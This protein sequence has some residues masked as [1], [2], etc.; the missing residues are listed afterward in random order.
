MVADQCPAE[1]KRTLGL[2]TL[3]L[4]GTEGV[5]PEEVMNNSARH[6]VKIVE[7]GCADLMK[8]V[9]QDPKT[10]THEK[11]TAIKTIHAKACDDLDHLRQSFT[12]IQDLNARRSEIMRALNQGPTKNYLYPFG[13]NSMSSSVSSL[14]SLV[15]DVSQAQ[16]IELQT[17]TQALLESVA[18]GLGSI[19]GSSNIYW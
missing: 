10:Q 11:L 17:A 5:L 18:D 6:I 2:V 4:L 1:T 16:G 13:F 14:L 8:T 12:N 3:R 15:T 7:E 9:I 19:R